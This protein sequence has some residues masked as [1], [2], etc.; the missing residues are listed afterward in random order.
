M[1][2]VQQ[3]MRAKLIPATGRVWFPLALAL[4][5]V[6]GFGAQA[7]DMKLQ[8]FLLWGTDDSKPPEG[9]A[10]QPVNPDIRQKLKDLPLKWT[11]WFEVK[12]VDFEVTQGATKEVTMSAKCQLNVSKLAGPELEVSLIGKGKEVVKR[13]Q[14]LPRGEMLV[15]GGNAPNSTAWL[16]VLKRIE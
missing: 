12:H 9:K 3:V 1:G 8:A 16:V 7:A 5:T 4:L 10:Y 6:A 14:P 11:N 15:L 13:K 2:T